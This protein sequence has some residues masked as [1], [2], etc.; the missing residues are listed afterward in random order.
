MPINNPFT[1]PVMLSTF[2]FSSMVQEGTSELSRS[3]TAVPDSF[4]HLQL[5]SFSSLASALSPKLSV[6]VEL[7]FISPS[8]SSRE[9]KTRA[10]LKQQQQQQQQIPESA[11]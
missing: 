6:F 4:L 10:P 2:P 1:L 9:A 11:P 3:F 7:I 5:P 8:L